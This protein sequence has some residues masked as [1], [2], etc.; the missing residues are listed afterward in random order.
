MTTQSKEQTASDDVKIRQAKAKALIDMIG[1]CVFLVVTGGQLLNQSRPALV[2]DICGGNQRKA[3]AILAQLGGMGGAAE[4]LF[5]P[6][7]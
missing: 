1:P 4:F 7:M 5:N 3:A 2:L 6:L